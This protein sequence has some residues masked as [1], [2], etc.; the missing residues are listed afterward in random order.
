[1]E[2]ELKVVSLK[3]SDLVPYENNAKIHTDAQIGHIAKSIE[4][5]GFADPV[6]VWTNS[7]GNPEIVYGHGAVMAAKRLGFEAVPCVF[8]NHL[9]DEQRRALCHIH[10]QTQQETGFDYEAL[11]ADMDNL[12]CAW[13]DYGFEAYCYD[14]SPEVEEDEVPEDVTCRCKPGDV[15]QLGRHRVMCASATDPEAVAILRGGALAD[16]LLTD[17][18][19]GVALGHHGRPSEAKQL[20]RRQDGLVIE[21]DSWD[22]DEDFRRFLESAFRCSLDAMRPG[23]AFYIFHADSKALPFRQASEDAG[24]TVRECLIWNKNAITLGRQDYQWKHEP[25]L[26]GWKDGAA[27]S[28]HSD[29]KQATVLDFDRPARSDEHPTMKP[30]PLLAYLIG[31]SSNEGDTI[32]DP[33]GGS[34]STLIACEQ[35]GRTCLTMDIDP[36]YCDVILSRWEQLTGDDARRVQR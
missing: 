31:N 16:M 27:H 25:C 26:Y 35:T 24:M 14:D 7:D 32:L 17:P 18:P 4:D 19:Y 15:W 8:L 6:G 28:W 36:H 34:G 11:T 22:S 3:V 10:N 5:F 13:E 20:H 29:R 9:S 12:N 21:N 1:M 30:I 2:A 23:A 33:F